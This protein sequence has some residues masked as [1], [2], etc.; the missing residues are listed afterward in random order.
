M[1]WW[2]RV[3]LAAALISLVLVTHFKRQATLKRRADELLRLGEA[4]ERA[5]EA[6]LGS[7]AELA[8]LTPR[9][10]EILQLLAEGLSTREIAERLGVSVKTIEAHRSNLMERLEIYDVPGLVRLAIRSRLVSLEN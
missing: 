1:T 8:A 7:E 10:K 5:L 2:F 3:L 4:R 6:Q 9:Q